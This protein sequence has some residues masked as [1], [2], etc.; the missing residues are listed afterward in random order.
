MDDN[1]RGTDQE[2][3]GEDPVL[4]ALVR[5]RLQP[6]GELQIDRRRL[7]VAQRERLP[8]LAQ[9]LLETRDELAALLDP[10][11]RRRGV[12]AGR[13]PLRPEKAVLIRP[14]HRNEPP[15]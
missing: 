9:L 1:A 14:Q 15:G 3:Q 2:V 11:E 10:F 5:C 4:T 6:F 7:P 13:H 8:R 12:A